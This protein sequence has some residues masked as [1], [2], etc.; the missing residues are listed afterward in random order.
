MVPCV[1]CIH[2]STNLVLFENHGLQCIDAAKAWL[3]QIDASDV[4]QIRVLTK[5]IIPVT[6]YTFKQVW[7]VYQANLFIEAGADP[8]SCQGFCSPVDRP[9]L[10]ESP[11][12]C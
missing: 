7:D 6:R 1:K 11:L 5:S 2:S 3:K 8:K 9:K 4:C 10:E 12:V